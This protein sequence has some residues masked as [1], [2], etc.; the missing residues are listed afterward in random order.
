AVPGAWLLARQ[1]GLDERGAGAVALLVALLPVT[2]WMGGDAPYPDVAFLPLGIFLVWAGLRENCILVL[3]SALAII[4]TSESG[5]LTLACAG[6]VLCALSRK[7]RWLWLVPVGIT[8]VPLALWFQDWV[9][10]GRA[11]G[12]LLYR[13]GIEAI[14][15]LLLLKVGLRVFWPSR[16]FSFLKLLLQAGH[17]TFAEFPLAALA[18]IPAA[19]QLAVIAGHTNQAQLGLY[20]G[21]YSLPLIVVAA[22]TALGRLRNTAFHAPLA[23]GLALVLGAR[24]YRVAPPASFVSR[25]EEMAALVPHDASV[26]A[27]PYVSMRLAKRPYLRIVQDTAELRDELSRTRP[28]VALERM[29]F[30]D[31]DAA[32]S[33]LLP[34]G[35]ERVFGDTCFVVWKPPEKSSP[36]KFGVLAPLMR[37]P[38]SPNKFGVLAP[39]MRLPAIN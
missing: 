39:L 7:K 32:G 36:N 29:S 3:V 37:L 24:F 30:Q 4:L 22:I 1:F 33:V 38:A 23:I 26:A 10:P 12:R 18:I 21:F 19:P 5:G 11:E 16:I 25:T 27:A 31:V 34:L 20:H 13:Y 6:V 8:A 35:Y 9:A 14:T 15:P 28:W 2:W 17:L